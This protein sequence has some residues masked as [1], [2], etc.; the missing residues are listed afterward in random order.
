MIRYEVTLQVEPALAQEVEQHM[1]GEHI[2]QIFATGCFQRIR[3]DQASAGRF[4]TS[5]EATSQAD[6][7]RYLHEHAPRFRTDF[8]TR[9]PTGITTTREIWAAREV[10]G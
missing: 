5:Y 1:R 10:W 2:P 6:L 8:Q 4:R 7:D 3:F 9:F